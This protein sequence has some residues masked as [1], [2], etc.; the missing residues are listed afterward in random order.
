MKQN[1]TLDLDALKQF[2]NIFDSLLEGIQI[3]D[4]DWNFIYV[5]ETLCKHVN[6]KKE[7]L[8]GQ[9]I[10]DKFPNIEKLKIFKVL[11]DCMIN[12]KTKQVQ[13]KYIFE[14]DT[15]KWFE[16]TIKPVKEGICILSLDSTEHKTLELQTEKISRLYAFISQVN[17]NIVRIKDEDALFKNSCKIATE[18]GKFKIAWI[19]LF[20][21]DKIILVEQ[22]GVSRKEIEKFNTLKDDYSKEEILEK[23]GFFIC[24][25]IQNDIKLLNWKPFI[26]HHGIC[27][28]IILP[29]KKANQIIGTLNLYSSEL[30]FFNH[31]EIELLI[32]VAGDISFAIDRFEKERQHKRN[33]EI[34][35]L[36]EKRFRALIENSNDVIAL[37]NRE[38][39]F[40]YGSPNFSK[41]LGYTSDEYLNLSAFSMTHPYNLAHFMEKINQILLIPGKSFTTQQRL[42][43]KNGKWI[44]CEGKVTNMMHLK[45]VNAIVINFRDISE[46]KKSEEKLLKSEAFSRNI[47]NSLSAHIAVIDTSGKIVAVND[48]W[49]RF[50]T[51]N[52]ETTI[53]N[54]G[55]GSN[56]FRVCKKSAETGDPSA[57]IVMEGLRN[58]MNKL[59]RNFYYE[60][61]C[62]S[63]S[64][65]RWFAMLAMPFDGDQE[66][67]VVAHQDI[68][69][70]KFAEDKLILKNQELEKTNFELD[71]FVYSVSHDL[72]SPLTSVL[73]LLSFIQEDTKEPD[74]LT[75]A[76]MIH[77]SINKL[78]EFIKNILSYS[79]NNRVELEIE[80]INLQETTE[81][82]VASRLYI[83]E[84][85]N[86]SFE[87]NFDEHCDFYSDKQSYTTVIEN[88]VSNAIKFKDR[89]KPNQIIKI[90][91]TSVDDTL[92]L[93]IFDNG[94]G[95]ASE[96]QT[97]IF[98]MFVRLSG[99]ID[100]AGIGLYIVKEIITKIEGTIEIQSIFG[101][102]TN[103][104]INL[105]NFKPC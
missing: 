43:H 6:L 53:H 25:D 57:T 15:A 65:E 66:L 12:R 44:W 18:F 81:K 98:D 88:L 75:H 94:I 96:N 22:S 19:G 4:F 58:V 95:I 70:R 101:K 45:S 14:D 52:N 31:E 71:R 50:A 24:N 2:Q 67:V 27:S 76:R 91:G 69:Q 28:C 33:E 62:H 104:K 32:E 80:K 37:C 49:D 20:E 68:S 40:I 9:N 47:I 89:N 17:Q 56:Y 87:I 13:N 79:R 83:K 48:A 86:I 34:I 41:I 84:A 97:K 73:G 29:I 5:N 35:L 3:I 61:P 8:I 92:S 7:A 36:N 42:R 64:R 16:L 1:N 30:T 21:D 38:G 23:D 77:E 100:G 46:K 82:I 72:R 26:E 90:I 99:E 105:K 54:T 93:E 60:Y 59:N 11:S 78:D 85:K 103:F 55:L 102:E 10:K 74:T 51:E 39:K 63:P